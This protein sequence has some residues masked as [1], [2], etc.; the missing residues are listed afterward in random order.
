MSN[1]V[2]AFY[3]G[4]G[5][6]RYLRK[7]LGAEYTTEGI[8]YDNRFRNQSF[9]HRY[10][11]GNVSPPGTDIILTHCMDV[12]RIREKLKP[13]QVLIIKTDLFK[14]LRREWILNGHKSYTQRHSEDREQTIVELYNAIKTPS[15]PVCNAHTDFVLLDDKYQQEVLNQMPTVPIELHSA[16]STI[17]WHSNY[18]KNTNIE[19]ATVL[20]DPEFM[21]V[22]ESELNNYNHP[23]FNF[24]WEQYNMHGADAPIVDLYNQHIREPGSRM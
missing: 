13:D 7:L 23:V 3:P 2:V 1:R 16:W 9:E 18:Y 20:D 14:S 17:T 24:C 5:G 22:I 4:G 11:I 15:W 6:N 10:L 21:T 19:S 12:D 8:A